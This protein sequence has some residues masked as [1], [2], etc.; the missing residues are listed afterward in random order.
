MNGV[1]QTVLVKLQYP[2]EITGLIIE[3]LEDF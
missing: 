2:S 1:I 3:D